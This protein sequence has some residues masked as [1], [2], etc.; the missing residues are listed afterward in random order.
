M[1]RLVVCCDGTWQSLTSAYPTNVVKMLQA[2]KPQGD[3]GVP[4]I[5]YYTEGVGAGN[6]LLNRLGGGAFGWGLDTVLQSAYRFLCLN[7]EPGDQLYLFGFSRGAYTARS[8]AGFVYNVGLLYR[9]HLRQ[10]P[11]A[12]T[13]YRDRGKETSPGSISAEQ[14]RQRYSQ[15]VDIT[16]LGCWDTVGSLGIPDRFPLIPLDRWLNRKYL[17]HDTCVNRRV[18]CARHAVA[19]DE[20]RKNFYVTPM[21]RSPGA[22]DQDLEQVWFPGDH[23]GVG[24]G[25]AAYQGLS[26]GALQW[27][28]D[29][30]TAQG[31]QL[32]SKAMAEGLKP[33]P[34]IFFDNTPKGLYAKLGIRIRRPEEHGADFA[35]IHPSTQTRW[36]SLPDYRPESLEGFAPQLDQGCAE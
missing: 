27:M 12:Y 13:L 9:H 10:V 6:N 20:L 23:G 29:A 11:Y 17:F 24:G 15:G 22:D 5:A 33:N 18:Q 4:Q 3:D 8:L 35:A 31:L 36:C 21:N 28:M 34:L 2:V 26:D 19:L 16:F 7:Y 14:F 1:K 32:R 30:A 25:T